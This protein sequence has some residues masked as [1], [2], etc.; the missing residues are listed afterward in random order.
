MPQ[1]EAMACGCPVISAHNSAMIEVVEGA[2]ETIK[3]WEKNEWIAAIELV[4][5][6]RDKYIDLGFKRVRD[7]ERERIIQDL[8][9]YINTKL[10]VD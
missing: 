4:D 9:K 2:G 6:T 8:T 10:S 3:S 5:K 1:L 7:Y